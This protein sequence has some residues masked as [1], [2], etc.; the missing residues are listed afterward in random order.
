MLNP[1]NKA[2]TVESKRLGHSLDGV[3]SAVSSI[4]IITEERNIESIPE[5]SNAVTSLSTLDDTIYS[6]VQLTG[7]YHSAFHY[8]LCLGF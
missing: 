6:Q 7:L 5:E 8:F 1:L 2:H 4:Q 3:E